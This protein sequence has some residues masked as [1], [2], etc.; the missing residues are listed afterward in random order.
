MKSGPPHHCRVIAQP[1]HFPLILSLSCTAISLH[2]HCTVP[3]FLF[4]GAAPSVIPLYHF[5]TPLFLHLSVPPFCHYSMHQ[6]HHSYHHSFYALIPPFC[7][8]S[9]AQ[10]PPFCLF[11]MHQQTLPFFHILVPL[12]KTG[13][14]CKAV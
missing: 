13:P 10:I 4:H 7:H 3:V 14:L 5:A 11:P 12:C 8:Y 1:F 2:K 9:Y 6:Y